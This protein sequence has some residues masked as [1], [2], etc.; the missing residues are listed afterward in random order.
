M[1]TTIKLSA[2]TRDRVNAV[3]ARTGQTADQVVRSALE[4]YERSLFWLAYAA[5]AGAVAADAEAAADER[6]EQELWD[7]TVQDGLERG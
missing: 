7:R 4:D 6:T 5:A 1:Q 2:A 3:G